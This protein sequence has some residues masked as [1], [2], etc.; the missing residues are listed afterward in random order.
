M[1]AYPKIAKIV[2]FKFVFVRNQNIFNF[3]GFN[4]TPSKFKLI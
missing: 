2:F 3:E 4:S 1:F